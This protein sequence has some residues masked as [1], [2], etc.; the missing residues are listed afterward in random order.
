[1]NWQIKNPS[2]M[3]KFREMVVEEKHLF[4]QFGTW[5]IL[6]TYILFFGAGN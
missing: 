6:G 5:N 4:I 3:S 2:L 1:M